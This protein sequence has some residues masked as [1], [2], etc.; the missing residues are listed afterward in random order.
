MWRLEHPDT[1]VSR[2]RRYRLSPLPIITSVKSGLR[3]LVSQRC[4]LS[5]TSL[6]RLG[7]PKRQDG[8][9]TQTQARRTR[10]NLCIQFLIPRFIFVIP[11]RD[12]DLPR[13]LS[14]ALN[15]PRHPLEYR[16]RHTS[17]PTAA[18]TQRN[19]LVRL[20]HRSL[21]PSVLAPAT[22]AV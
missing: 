7:A 18:L 3:A 9:P 1:R 11:S 21:A 2:F 20:P 22:C 12:G 17:R 5:I 8:E 15:F 4:H 10:T 6:P 14:F 19:E 16:P 13:C